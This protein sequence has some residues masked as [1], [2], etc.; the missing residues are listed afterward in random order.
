VPIRVTTAGGPVRVPPVARYHLL[1]IIREAVHNAVEHS[2]G[3]AVDVRL[4]EE[5]GLVVATVADDGTG[6]DLATRERASGHFGIRGM[7][8]RARR[9]GGTLAIES[10]PGDGTRVT[11]TVPVARADAAGGP[12]AAIGRS[13]SVPRLGVSS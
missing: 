10:R 5:R 7:Q 3:T 12:A 9:I 13:A 11:V 4:T 2:G 8:E 6:F 1:R